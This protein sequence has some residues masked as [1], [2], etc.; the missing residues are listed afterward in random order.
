MY[1]SFEWDEEKN[2]ENQIK[3]GVSFEDA[4]KA[5]DDPNLLLFEDE[6]HSTSEERRYFCIAKVGTGIMAVRFTYRGNKIRIFGAGYWRKYRKLY[7]R[8]EKL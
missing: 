6:L 3:H 2:Q 8:K 4:Q 7:S 5:F 1:E